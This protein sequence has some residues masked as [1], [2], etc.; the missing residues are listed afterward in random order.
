MPFFIGV[1]TY[2]PGLT[3]GGRDYLNW[4]IPQLKDRIWSR[5]TLWG[6]EVACRDAA[7]VIEHLNFEVTTRR[8]WA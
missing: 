2:R 7:L 5:L 1:G 4:R 6:S 8:W 3:A